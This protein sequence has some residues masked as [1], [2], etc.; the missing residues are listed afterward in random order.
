MFPKDS[1]FSQPQ[2][3]NK[4][5]AEELKLTFFTDF[6]GK[7]HLPT[8]VKSLLSGRRRVNREISALTKL[9]LKKS[10]IC[11]YDI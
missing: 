1:D 3:Q 8:R 6:Y 7:N 5:I 4:K 10:E 9:T 11:F 2:V